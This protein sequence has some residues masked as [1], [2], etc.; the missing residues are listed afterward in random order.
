MREMTDVHYFEADRGPMTNAE[1]ASA[2]AK[3]SGHKTIIVLA[4]D[5]A[6]IGE[7][8]FHIG[9]IVR[10]S[11]VNPNKPPIFTVQNYGDAFAHLMTRSAFS[12][13]HEVPEPAA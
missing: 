6:L 1:G 12:F 2:L 10:S 9:N 13:C 11:E 8:S 5:S 4:C 3:A 7:G